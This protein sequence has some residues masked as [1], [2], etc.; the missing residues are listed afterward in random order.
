MF[1]PPQ[2]RAQEQQGSGCDGPRHA[3]AHADAWPGKLNDLDIQ[4]MVSNEL[5]RQ[6]NLHLQVELEVLK[7][8]RERDLH[9]YTGAPI[10]RELTNSEGVTSPR[11]P[12]DKLYSQLSLPKRSKD[13]EEELNEFEKSALLQVIHDYV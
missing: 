13:L 1:D 11:D 6:K 4:L 7:Q 2:K 10:P 12:Y 5:L 3:V 8:G 9:H